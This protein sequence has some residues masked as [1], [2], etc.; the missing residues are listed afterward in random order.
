MCSHFCRNQRNHFANC[1]KRL[2]IRAFISIITRDG[3]RNSLGG[4]RAGAD[5][6]FEGSMGHGDNTSQGAPTGPWPL[7]SPVGSSQNLCIC[8]QVCRYAQCTPRCSHRHRHASTSHVCTSTQVHT[9]P[10]A[11]TPPNLV[12]SS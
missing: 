3:Q 6:P 12:H 7:V 11:H 5:T 4:V 1:R 9:I 10:C 8:R 2:E